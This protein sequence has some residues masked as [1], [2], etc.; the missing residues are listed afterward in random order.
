ML[1]VMV[2][3]KLKWCFCRHSYECCKY[4]T[5]LVSSF[6]LITFEKNEM[7][8]INISDT[9]KVIMD[10]IN[11]RCSIVSSQALTFCIYSFIELIGHFLI[12]NT[13][14]SIL[15]SKCSEK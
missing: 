13:D 2:R 10:I 12:I 4:H 9:K 11:A 6:I 1:Q 7:K 14:Y 15:N 5:K 3:D 8:A